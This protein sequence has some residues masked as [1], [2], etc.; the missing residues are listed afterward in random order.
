[1]HSNMAEVVLAAFCHDKFG[2]GKKFAFATLPTSRMELEVLARV[3]DAIVLVHECTASLQF[4][5]A[6]A[7]HS[8]HLLEHVLHTPIKAWTELSTLI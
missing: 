1:M 3:E 5:R 7:S 2:L 4:A 8:C 6:N